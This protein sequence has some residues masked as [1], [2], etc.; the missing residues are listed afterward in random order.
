MKS[1]KTDAHLDDPPGIRIPDITHETI[2]KVKFFNAKAQSRQDFQ[3][4]ISLSHAHAKKEHRFYVTTLISL[5]YGL[6]QKN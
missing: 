3:K 4:A 2:I 1:P 5:R 6:S